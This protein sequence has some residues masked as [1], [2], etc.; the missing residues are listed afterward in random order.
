MVTCFRGDRNETTTRDIDGTKSVCPKRVCDRC[1]GATMEDSSTKDSTNAL[2]ER[3]S[4][5]G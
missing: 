3:I 1:R 4:M 5:I 2:K